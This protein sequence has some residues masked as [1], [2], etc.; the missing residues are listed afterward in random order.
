MNA[1]AGIGLALV[2]SLV[3]LGGLGA[4]TPPA[5]DSTP[6]GQAPPASTAY[7]G[8]QTPTAPP[9]TSASTA[10]PAAGPGSQATVPGQLSNWITNTQPGCCAPIGGNGPITYDLYLRTGPDFVAGSG[11]LAKQ[12]E[13]GWEVEGGGRSL[14]FNVPETAAWV[15]DLGFKYTYNHS[16]KNPTPFIDLFGNLESVKQLNRQLV[17]V[18]FGREWYLTGSANTCDV[19]WLAGVD[20]GGLYGPAR[21]KL[22]DLNLNPFTGLPLGGGTHMSDVV[23]AAYI[24]VYSGLEV[25]CGCCKWEFGLRFE[26]D[27]T[28][29]DILPQDSDVQDLNLL[30]TAGVRF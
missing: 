13:I 4:Q 26:Y 9:G 23:G 27:Y 3:D 20:A 19:K 12:L 30:L 1:K 7:P 25:P 17:R 11:F 21:L 16:V 6:Y 24:A 14:F 18:G 28:W 2:L 15:V 5:F 10:T 29:Q 22:N 8:T